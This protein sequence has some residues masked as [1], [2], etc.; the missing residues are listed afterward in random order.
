[1]VG[2]DGQKGVCMRLLSNEPAG[3][4]LF[5]GKAQDRIASLMFDTFE[6]ARRSKGGEQIVGSA[7]VGIEGEWG[8]GKSNVVKILESKFTAAKGGEYCLFNFDLWGRQSDVHRKI[9]LEE[10][11]SFLKSE[12]CIDK[13]DE[14]RKL[15]LKKT[16]TEA[17]FARKDIW[18]RLVP[19]CLGGLI[20]FVLSLGVA[21]GAS[22]PKLSECL[23]WSVVAC[24]FGVLA[25]CIIL[26][27]R[28]NDALVSLSEFLGN[29]LQITTKGDGLPRIQ[30][31]YQYNVTVADFTN[32]MVE[33]SDELSKT[34]KQLVMVFDN[35][36]RLGEACVR[37]F[38][39]SLHILFAERKTSYLANIHVIVPFDRKRIREAFG[40]G[41]GDDYINKTFDV[42]YRVAPPILRDWKGYFQRKLSESASEDGHVT[43]QD[44][45]DV[46][47]YFDLLYG[48]SG[49]K[50]REIVGFINELATIR[51]VLGPEIPLKYIALYLLSWQSCECTKEID[52]DSQ[53]LAGGFIGNEYL[54]TMYQEN[55]SAKKYMASIVYQVAPEKGAEIL[56]GARLLKALNEGDP[57]VVVEMAGDNDFHALYRR[58]VAGKI[59]LRKAPFALSGLAGEMN[60]RYWNELYA[61]HADE[62]AQLSQ[63]PKCIEECHGLLLR[64]V[65]GWKKL[66]LSLRDR[67]AKNQVEIEDQCQLTLQIQVALK[68]SGRKLDGVFEH[69]V[70]TA[71]EFLAML[72]VLK[73]DYGIMNWECD[74]VD[75]DRQAASIVPDDLERVSGLAYLD[76]GNEDL[77]P[78][79]RK[80]LEAVS[81]RRS[82]SN[83]RVGI[84]LHILENVKKP[85]ALLSTSLDE[86]DAYDYAEEEA[87]TDEE[88]SRAVAFA[89]SKDSESTLGIKKIKEFLHRGEDT[90]AKMFKQKTLKYMSPSGILRQ[91]P[92]MKEFSLYNMMARL[93]LEDEN[94]TYQRDNAK[95]IL[96]HLCEITSIMGVAPEMFFRCMPDMKWA[97]LSLEEMSVVLNAQTLQLLKKS[98]HD[99]AASAVDWVRR[100]LESVDNMGWE[101]ALESEE[102]D[103]RIKAAEV[104]EFRWPTGI[105]DVTNEVLHEVVDEEVAIPSES[106]WRIFVDTARRQRIKISSLFKECKEYILSRDEDLSPGVFLFLAPYIFKH[107]SLGKNP[108]ELEKLLPKD[109]VLLDDDCRTFIG[110]HSEDIRKMLRRSKTIDDF[111]SFL[112][113][114]QEN[115]PQSPLSSLFDLVS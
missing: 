17:Q 8:A 108:N 7:V 106:N 18:R 57:T 38:W 113:D 109:T 83:R 65:D 63:T 24:T 79:S 13:S 90:L 95:Y 71:D 87:E 46:S 85:R 105:G 19:I 49:V 72:R 84:L 76:L 93:V 53:I 14:V 15:V 29:M 33:L 103:W 39:S 51:N 78:N 6:K 80:A 86:Q 50:P 101:E 40:E 27:V 4:D 43:G 10:L 115:D 112:K 102:E 88:M 92:R 16:Q 75:L 34:G 59:N 26:E 91:V 107:G 41:D 1:M 99:F 58:V 44:I 96:K 48:K 69:R 97:E 23:I 100:Y 68:G 31:E 110:T 35:M 81:W 104:V 89:L 114:V 45:K 70:I 3:I 62:Y 60:R 32:F 73:S 54:K 2:L 56:L 21:M 52:I 11:A 74:I 77:L 20:P 66:V 37:E 9:I 111:V 61:S 98:E 30:Y 94:V 55:A 42:V 28:K 64:N 67:L 22:Y 47:D 82:S 5:E 12:C 36:D 25:W